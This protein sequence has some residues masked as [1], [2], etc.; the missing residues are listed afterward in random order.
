[1]GWQIYHDSSYTGVEVNKSYLGKKQ[2]QWLKDNLANS[3]ASFKFIVSGS[4]VLNTEGHGEC[5][6]HYTE[7]WQ[8]LLDFI[9]EYKINGVIFLSGDRHYS[10][11]LK[12]QKGGQ[13]PLYEITSSPMAARPYFSV[14]KSKEA[15]NPLRVEGTLTNELNFMRLS[16]S[17]E[18]YK[19]VLKVEDFDRDGKKLWE[20]TIPQMELRF[21][22]K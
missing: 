6:C 13:Y 14:K 8:E 11:V 5:F 12:F 16:V 15:N 1:M 9:K 17:G 3:H 2:L 20:I 10:E 21:I 19:R 4:Q 18:R 7:E 22:R